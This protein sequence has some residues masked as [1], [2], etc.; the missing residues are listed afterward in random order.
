MTPDL[1]GAPYLTYIG[2]TDSEV[3]RALDVASDG[4]V[5]IGGVTASPNFPVT[6]GGSTAPN[7]GAD[8]GWFAL[9]TH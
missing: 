9:L 1:K 3:S 5:A 7:G 4:A 6:A 2:G 8:T